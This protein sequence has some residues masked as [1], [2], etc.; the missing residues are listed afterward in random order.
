MDQTSRSA[1]PRIMVAPNGARRSKV[2][3]PALPITIP[4][5]V[6]TAIACRNAGADGIHAHLRDEMGAHL[7]DAGLYRELQDELKQNIPDMFI[8]ITTEAVGIY[9]PAQQRAIVEQAAPSAVSISIKEMLSEGQNPNISHFYHDQSHKGVAIQHILYSAEETEKLT[10][11]CKSGFLPTDN[12]QLLFVLGRYSQGQ[13]SEPSDLD[14]F[15][16]SLEKMKGVLGLDPDW[17]CC[18]FGMHETDCL[19]HAFANGGKARI[20]FENN[21]FMKDGRL[22]RDNAERVEEL[23]ANQI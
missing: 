8:Q 11:L 10:E 20:G 19:L 21:L 14:P 9:N 15:L 3:H 5:V 7:L 13:K 6:E 16:A 2:D 18:A 17:G 1:L 22:A 4:E 23:I 12:L